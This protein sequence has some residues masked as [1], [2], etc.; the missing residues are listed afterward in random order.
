MNN[1][2]SSRPMVSLAGNPL[3]QFLES[4]SW[5]I[6]IEENILIL[7]IFFSWSRLK[8]HLGTCR[9]QCNTW[10]CPIGHYSKAWTC[11]MKQLVKDVLRPLNSPKWSPQSTSYHPLWCLS[12]PARVM[13]SLN[14]FLMIPIISHTPS[15][16]CQEDVTIKRQNLFCWESTKQVT[17]YRSKNEHVCCCGGVSIV[18]LFFALPIMYHRRYTHTYNTIKASM[19]FDLKSHSVFVRFRWFSVHVMPI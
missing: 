6:F 19:K 12:L 18:L 10:L 7:N 8:R 11:L 1:T 17:K 9:M 13:V 15:S 4:A 2:Y 3:K 5:N 16:P 14:S